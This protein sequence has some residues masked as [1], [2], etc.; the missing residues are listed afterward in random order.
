MRT[1]KKQF[2]SIE[3]EGHGGDVGGQEGCPKSGNIQVRGG[4]KGKGHAGR[5]V[6]PQG[7]LHVGRRSGEERLLFS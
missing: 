1:P 6:Y 4:F 2:L 7:E 3:V 5:S